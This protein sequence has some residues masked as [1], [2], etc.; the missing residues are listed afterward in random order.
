[1]DRVRS[2][3]LVFVILAPGLA[4]PLEAGTYPDRFVWVFGWNLGQDRDVDEITEVLETAA[5]HKINGAVMSLG[6]D[7]LCKKSPDY[8]RRLEQV[9]EVC[10]RRKLELIPAVFSVGYGGAALAHD[11]NLAAGVPVVDAPFVVVGGEAKL[12]PD[13]AIALANGGFEEHSGNRLSGYRFHDQPG[14]VTFVDTKIRH[15]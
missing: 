9:R 7:T 4:A 11:K 10:R 5:D 3:L 12:V 6:L 2:V 14:E 1:M 15:G 13:P 8:F